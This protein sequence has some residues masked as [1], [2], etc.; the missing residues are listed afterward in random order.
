MQDIKSPNVLLGSD[1]T[2]KIADV[3]V[4]LLYDDVI[5]QPLPSFP[6][7]TAGTTSMTLPQH[8]CLPYTGRP[9]EIAEQGLSVRTGGDW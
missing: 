1:F 6:V 7:V 3:S 5:V 2:A 4:S 8:A 9:G